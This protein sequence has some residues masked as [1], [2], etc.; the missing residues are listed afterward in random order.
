MR[1]ISTRTTYQEHELEIEFCIG[2]YLNAKWLLV[3]EPLNRDLGEIYNLGNDELVLISY[4]TPLI[5]KLW[6]API[7]DL[8]SYEKATRRAN[9]SKSIED[10]L[11][12]RSYETEIELDG[13]RVTVPVKLI[14]RH[15]F[16]TEGVGFD[17]EYVTGVS[18]YVEV[19]WEE[20]I[21]SD[22]WHDYDADYYDKTLVDR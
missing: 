14:R 8:I 10:N 2:D 4:D 13:R 12:V 21:D 18:F 16:D 1:V 15:G 5:E 22:E 11:V 17:L 6:G 9:Y 20:Y 7:S 3:D 19:M